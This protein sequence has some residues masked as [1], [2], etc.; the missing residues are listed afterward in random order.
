M[1]ATST[2]CSTVSDLSESETLSHSDATG[3]T[4][5]SAAS[6]SASTIDDASSELVVELWDKPHQPRSGV[7]PKRQ[8]SVLEKA[9]VGKHIV[10]ED[11]KDIVQHFKEDLEE[12]ELLMELKMVKNMYCE[13]IFS[14]STLKEKNCPL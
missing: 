1:D 3:T 12:S 10:A 14:Y 11:V 13:K 2:D 6:I 9:A 8:E 5:T 4:S 7:F